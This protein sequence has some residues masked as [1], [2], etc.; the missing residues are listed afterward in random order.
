MAE[1]EHKLQLKLKEL[2]EHRLQLEERRLQREDQRRKTKEQEK[3]QLKEYELKVMST[4]LE[5]AGPKRHA[6]GSSENNG[7]LTSALRENRRQMKCTR[8]TRRYAHVSTILL[9][10]I[11]NC[12]LFVL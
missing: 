1:V 2:E 6:D 4:K 7:K 11:F 8:I 9:C 10:Y 3:R 5:D 12:V